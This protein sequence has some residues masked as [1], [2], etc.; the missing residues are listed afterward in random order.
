MLESTVP[1]EMPIASVVAVLLHN[2]P[3]GLGFLVRPRGLLRS[4]VGD[5]PW[6]AF[7]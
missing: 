5:D 7:F 4:L 3:L 1:Y 2:V 6:L